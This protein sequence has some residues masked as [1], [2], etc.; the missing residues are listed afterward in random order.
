M[1]WRPFGESQTRISDRTIWEVYFTLFTVVIKGVNS[2]PSECHG[3]VITCCNGEHI[4]R[5]FYSV[6]MEAMYSLPW[7]AG[8]KGRPSTF[9]TEA[10]L[11]MLLLK[12]RQVFSLARASG[13]SALWTPEAQGS[14]ASVPGRR[15]ESRCGTTQALP[16]CFVH[17]RSD[18]K[19]QM[20]LQT[21]RNGKRKRRGPN[22][23]PCATPLGSS[24]HLIVR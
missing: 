2:F 6:I 9:R 15:A 5:Q 19:I 21:T 22:T 4:G 17:I 12:I 1:K 23:K 14:V 3:G 7:V 16:P 20:V 11:R 24:D 10:L 8:V 13:C 18:Q